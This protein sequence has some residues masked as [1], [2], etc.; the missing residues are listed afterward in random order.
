MPLP[1]PP[2]V[3]PKKPPDAANLIYIGTHNPES[4]GTKGTQGQLVMGDGVPMPTGKLLGLHVS[5]FLRDCYPLIG[6]D[7]KGSYTVNFGSSGAFLFDLRQ[8]FST[9]VPPRASLHPA[10]SAADRRTLARRAELQRKVGLM[11][12]PCPCG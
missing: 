2:V 9:V 5:N 1:S 11:P 4:T 7:S 10:F 12:Q 3:T 6:I 8:H